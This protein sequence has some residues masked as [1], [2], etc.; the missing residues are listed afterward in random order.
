MQGLF[1]VSRSTYCIH[2]HHYRMEQYGVFSTHR[3]GNEHNRNHIST[4]TTGEQCLHTL[5]IFPVCRGN[6]P[7]SA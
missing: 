4:T 3:C 5:G 7:I 6:H 1:I 2:Q